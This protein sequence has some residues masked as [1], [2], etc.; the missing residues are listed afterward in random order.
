MLRQTQIVVRREID[1]LWGSQRSLQTGTF[2]FGQA[3]ANSSFQNFVHCALVHRSNETP[4]FSNSPWSDWDSGFGVVRS[5][6]PKK[7]EFAPARK[8][9]ACASGESSSRPALSRTFERGIM[10]RAVA[11]I[12]TNSNGSSGGRL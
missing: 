9:R 12:R 3:S 8:Q 10:I 7:T 11:I 5:F 2:D 4:S 6:S 1:P